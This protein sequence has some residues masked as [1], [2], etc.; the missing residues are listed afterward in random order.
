MTHT[1]LDED[2]AQ[3]SAVNSREGCAGDDDPTGIAWG[4]FA[5]PIAL[6]A[7][8][9]SVSLAVWMAKNWPLW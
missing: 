1:Q 4:V 9:G 2:R 8:I 6:F 7:I 3:M 5:W